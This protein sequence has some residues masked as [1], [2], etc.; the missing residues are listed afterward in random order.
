MHES[1]CKDDIVAE[2]ARRLSEKID[3][4]AAL[5]IGQPATCDRLSDL[6]GIPA[7]R[8]EAPQEQ[9]GRR[10][11]ATK[12]ASLVLANAMIFQEQLAIS[13]TEG[14]VNSLRACDDVSDPVDSFRRHWSEIW[15]KI[16]YVPV[17]QLGE[18]VLGEMP[19]SP[20]AVS[21]IRWLMDEA[22][23]ICINQSALRHDLMGRIYH[24]LLHH[25]KYLGTYYTATSSATL[26]LKLVFAQSWEGRDFGSPK[27]LEDFV[28]ADPA[29]GTGTL[30]MAAAQALTDQFVVSRVKTGRKIG[31]KSL[32]SLHRTVMEKM[33][34]GYDVLPSAVHLT[35]STLGMLAPHVTYRSMNLFVMPMGV[36]NR[37]PRL[38]SL[39]FIDQKRVRTQIALDNT[40]MEIRQTGVRG[41]KFTSAEIP[42]MDLC[43]M[44][45]PFVRSTG[46]NLLFGSLPE[47]E[48]AKLQTE[49]KKRSKDL[50]ASVTAGL[51]SVFLAM[52]DK[53]LRAGGRLAFIL[54]ASI[55]TGEAWGASRRLLAEG[56]HVEF[57][58]V[59]HD[60]ERP[61]FS[62]NTALSEL[63]FIARKLRED[64]KP[65][66]TLYVNLWRNPHTIYEA[67][68]VAGG[69]R[70]CSPVSLDSKEITTIIGAGDRKFAEVVS[71]PPSQG[72][73]QWIGVQFA[74]TWTLR[75]AVKL[76]Q[77]QLEIPG[78]DPVAVPLCKIAELG[79]LGYDSRDI[80]D[81]FTVS[82]TDW[83]PYPAFWNHDA[84]EVVKLKQN[85]NAH[86]LPRS[87]AA[88]GRKL[89]DC[90]KIA[91]NAGRILLVERLWPITHRVMAV[92]FDEPV[93]GN[94]WWALKTELSG[95]Q[96][97]A[98]LLWLNSSPAL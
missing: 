38:G 37:S 79:N 14:R 56:Y 88:K 53:Y 96:E 3:S 92:S 18:A 70:I 11:T 8:G 48:R 76:E 75:T 66:E 39:D 93:L 29:C 9:T 32:G 30:L 86:L 60:A 68:S 87:V 95:E 12:V 61:N 67:L 21:A 91:E 33:L 57:V 45:P 22:K 7:K 19:A 27:K 54:P 55:A 1:L 71:L 50:R 28:I 69:V 20:N 84:N 41:E 78:R 31:E 36:K 74:Q 42:E 58:M 90:K 81:A 98:L 64:E 46:G 4:I 35:A 51:G 97:K 43:V 15:K 72:E 16:D 13:G 40:Q 52:A 65:G 82:E 25:A 63:M 47:A 94:T 83:S 85:N 17:F 10:I 49:L 34:Y 44:N 59:S 23:S 5:W 26:L 62:E 80:H 77:G 73:E 2:A 24:W 89:K 6:L